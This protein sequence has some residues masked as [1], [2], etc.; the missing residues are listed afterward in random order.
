MIS[1]LSIVSPVVVSHS[2]HDDDPC[3]YGHSEK[4]AGDEGYEGHHGNNTEVPFSISVSKRERWYM[5]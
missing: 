2:H 1:S 4:Q 3:P 5:A